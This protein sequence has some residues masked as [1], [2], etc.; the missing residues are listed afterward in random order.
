MKWHIIYRTS[1]GAFISH[2]EGEIIPASILPEWTTYTVPDRLNHLFR[3]NTATQAFDL[4]LR[5]SRLINS[6]D[7]MLRFLK[8]KRHALNN[9]N[10]NDVV[11]FREMLRLSSGEINLNDEFIVET[12]AAFVPEFLNESEVDDILR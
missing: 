9:S 11:D 8:T 5:R 7:F 3:W 6:S 10:R 12:L 1:D 4:P 2:G